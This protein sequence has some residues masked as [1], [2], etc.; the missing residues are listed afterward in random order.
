MLTAPQR[1]DREDVTRSDNVNK[2]QGRYLRV[3]SKLDHTLVYV[4][5]WLG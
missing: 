5:L 1:E 3:D 2:G 4:E